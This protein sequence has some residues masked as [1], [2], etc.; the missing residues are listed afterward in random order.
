MRKHNTRSHKKR[1]RE[2]KVT[3]MSFSNVLGGHS[4]SPS[5][6]FSVAQELFILE[7]MVRCVVADLGAAVYFD[8]PRIVVGGCSLSRYLYTR[9]A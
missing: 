8:P 5:H 1:K 2:K 3:W 4:S 7:F 9:Y 6:I